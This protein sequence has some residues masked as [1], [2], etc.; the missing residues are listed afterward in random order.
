MKLSQTLFIP[1]WHEKVV[2]SP[3]GPYPNILSHTDKLKAIIG[4]LQAGQ[5][6]PPHADSLAVYYFLE[7]TGWMTVD[8]ERYPVLSGTI[9]ITPDGSKRGVEADTRLAFLA[10]RIA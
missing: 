8:D 3:D 1:D 10:V 4:G 9:I 6:I 5:V 2:F 7:G